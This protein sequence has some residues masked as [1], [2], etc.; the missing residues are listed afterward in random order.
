MLQSIF[1]SNQL[2][3]G[4]TGNTGKESLWDPVAKVTR[5]LGGSHRAF[6]LHPDVKKG[7]DKRGVA[8]DTPF[9]VDTPEAFVEGADII[10]SFGGDGTLLNTARMVGDKDVPILGVNY[11]RLGFLANVEAADLDD[12]LD[13]IEAGDYLIERRLV[14]DCTLTENGRSVHRR[15]LNDCTLQRSGDAGLMTIDVLVD[16]RLMNTYWADGLIVSTPTGSTAYSLALGGPIMAPGCGGILIT[17]IAPHT[18]TVRP[19][20]LP[21]T[22]HIEIRVT[23]KRRKYVITADGDADLFEDESATVS[24][25]KADHSVSL[26]RFPDQDYFTTLRNKLMWGARKAL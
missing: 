23:G 20:V 24:I 26:V 4:I 13:R 12:A 15:A 18:L 6:V 9:T 2:R 11:G 7:L 19:V 1:G 10:L 25:K 14:L 22:A 3:I 17:P 8:V 16:D 21:E 5:A